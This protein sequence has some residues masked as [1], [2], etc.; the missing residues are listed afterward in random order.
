MSNA[1]LLSILS[2]KILRLHSTGT[3]PSLHLVRSAF[4][5]PP[6]WGVGRDERIDTR[7]YEM[8]RY[9][10]WEPLPAEVAG[11]EQDPDNYTPEW[12]PNLVLVNE[13]SV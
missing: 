11:F 10:L 6:L 12:I 4:Y 2:H 8:E 7:A 5:L 13:K 3:P 1:L 9:L